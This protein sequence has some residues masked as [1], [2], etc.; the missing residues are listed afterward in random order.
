MTP[1]ETQVIFQTPNFQWTNGRKM[2]KGY[3]VMAFDTSFHFI[4]PEVPWFHQHKQK[5][6]D[7]SI[8]L[9][10]YQHRIITPNTYPKN[11]LRI[12]RLVSSW[13]N[14]IVSQPI[15]GTFTITD[16]TTIGQESKLN[17]WSL[18]YQSNLL[19]CIP[20]LIQG[21]W[22]PSTP[23]NLKSTRNIIGRIP[24]HTILGKHVVKTHWHGFF[25]VLDFRV[26]IT[27]PTN[28]CIS[29]FWCITCCS[30]YHHHYR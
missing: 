30:Y 27:N 2:E 28:V 21:Y 26:S 23:P 6:C 29:C 5:P 14:H 7:L 25:W 22:L 18:V 11:S 17:H 24:L 15:M 12:H 19:A 4:T 10:W 16:S 8:N 1:L 9:R 3:V 20:L 13:Q